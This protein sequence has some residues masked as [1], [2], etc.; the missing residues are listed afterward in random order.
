MVKVILG[1]T[2]RSRTDLLPPPSG[3]AG[4]LPNI[5]Q[6]RN[7]KKILLKMSMVRRI[8][9]QELIGTQPLESAGD[10]KKQTTRGS[11]SRRARL[12]KLLAK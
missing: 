2:V 1:G 4:P 10:Q 12:K 3:P 9:A 6:D 7:R 5:G 11:V 8:E